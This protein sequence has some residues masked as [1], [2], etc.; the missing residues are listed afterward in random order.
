MISLKS[1]EIRRHSSRSGLKWP[2]RRLVTSYS[3]S[4][5]GRRSAAAVVR[6]KLA[7]SVLPRP[8]RSLQTT[9]VP[10]L[11]APLFPRVGRPAP[12]AAA[13][14]PFGAATGDAAAGGSGAG[15]A[16]TGDAAVGGSG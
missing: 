1:C 5:A 7:S 14:P 3:T 8:P 16:A 9:I 15:D 11:I 10:V 4:R 13:V 6:R 2:S 12:P